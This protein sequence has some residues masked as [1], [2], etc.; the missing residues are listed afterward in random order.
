MTQEDALTIL[1]TGRNVYLTG[2]AGSGKT[3]VLNTYIEYLKER[4][5]S[6]GV[7]ASTGIAATHLGGVTI[8]SWSGIGIKDYLTDQDIEFLTQKE[9]LWKRFDKTKVLIIDEVSMLA[10]GMFDSLDMLARAMKR[11]DRPFGGMQV[12]LSGDFFQLPPI[13]KGGGDIEFI[14][15]SRAWRGMDIRVCYLQEQFRQNDASLEGLLSKMRNAH[16]LAEVFDVLNQKQAEGNTLS[17]T[18]TR[19]YTHNVDVDAENEAELAKLPGREHVFDMEHKGRAN[20]VESLK[21]SV[22]APEQLC[23]KKNAVV[24]FVKNGFDEG[25]VNGT[26]G[27]ISSFN[28]EGL[29]IVKKANGEEITARPVEW[30]IEEDGKTLCSITQIPLRLAWA[31]TIHKSQG[32]SM[33]AAEV[34]LSRA[35]TPGQGYVAL[36]RLRTLEGLCLKGI[37][38]QACAIHPHVKAIDAHLVNES[39]KWQQVIKRFTEEQMK[40]MQTTFIKEAGGTNDPKEIQ[41]NRSKQKEGPKERIPTHEQTREL[42]K[43]GL[44]LAQIAEKRGQTLGTI[45]N[46]CEKLKELGADVD[47]SPFKPKQEDINAIHKA[48]WATKDTKLSPVHKKLGGKYSY[49]DLRLARLFLE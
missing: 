37:N 1:K 48:F 46:H 38:E 18:P 32:M 42:I 14:T 17:V 15:Q 36:S 43:E 40:E 4:G 44:T 28:S 29:P 8:H 11:V 49:E 12:V 45:L 9:Y 27:T 31:I 26:L 22:L 34:D 24:M 21:K 41:K 7:T 5:V 39:A 33:D 25:Y 2:A 30:T 16:D 35:F 19:L 20:M 13:V 6:V 10:P 47:F 3:H 23:L